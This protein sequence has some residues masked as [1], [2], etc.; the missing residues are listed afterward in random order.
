LGTPSRETAII[1]S[2]FAIL[3]EIDRS[4]RL[5]GTAMLKG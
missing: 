1:P 3:T 5:F 2:I 4:R